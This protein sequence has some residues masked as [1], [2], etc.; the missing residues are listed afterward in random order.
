MFKLE[1]VAK[2][3]QLNV[4]IRPKSKILTRPFLFA[5]TYAVF[6][7]LLA[8]LVF[9]ITP[10]KIDYNLFILPQ[11]KVATDISFLN[12]IYTAELSTEEENI[13]AYLIAPM[14][15]SPSL[16]TLQ[17]ATLMK[18][19]EYIKQSNPLSNPFLALE[20]IYAQDINLDSP[21]KGKSPLIQLSGPIS[22]LHFVYNEPAVSHEAHQ[23]ATHH[24]LYSV[25]LDTKNG[26]LFWWDLKAGERDVNAQKYAV[27]ILKNLVFEPS[28]DI[29]PV[30]GE[31]SLS[32]V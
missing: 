6:I 16:P 9:Q 11:V 18:N 13:P 10:L 26:E 22:N 27:H 15:Q 30:F 24:F 25:Q 12:G 3:D 4:L 28:D 1:R 19:M 8:L 23:S 17:N 7:H 21:A 32:F 20:Q 14:L 2:S 5:L 29:A 31:I